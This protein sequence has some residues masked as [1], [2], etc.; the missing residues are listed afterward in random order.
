[1][2]G[3]PEP[4]I[5]TA[6]GLPTQVCADAFDTIE[7]K[8]SSEMT[9]RRNMGGPLPQDGRAAMISRQYTL[10]HKIAFSL[11]AAARGK[12]Y[13]AALDWITTTVNTTKFRRPRE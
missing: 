13:S 6:T 7:K 4:R 9:V 11:Y 5:C 2:A 1:M 3:P 8:P 10:H 12:V